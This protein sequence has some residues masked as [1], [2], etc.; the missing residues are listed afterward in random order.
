MSSALPSEALPERQAAP[1]RSIRAAQQ[2]NRTRLAQAQSLHARNSS[3][4]QNH[5]PLTAK[6]MKGMGDLSRSQR[7][8]GPKCSS[9]GPCRPCG[10]GSA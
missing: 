6:R 5:K 2:T 8:T 9:M 7:P 1:N 10:I 4:L 3:D